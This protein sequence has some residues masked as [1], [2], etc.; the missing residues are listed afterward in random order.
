MYGLKEKN[1]K[2]P[3]KKILFLQN[4]DLVAKYE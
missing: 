1:R 2:K 3:T 4:S